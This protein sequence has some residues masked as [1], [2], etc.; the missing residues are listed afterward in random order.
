[1]ASYSSKANPIGSKTAWQEAH[2]GLRR[3]IAERSLAVAVG[4][5]FI[6]LVSTPAGGG[7]MLVHKMASR[8]S[9]PRRMNEVRFSWARPASMPAWVSR[10][11]RSV[12]FMSALA[13]VPA[14]AP[15]GLG[16]P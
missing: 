12:A 2:S 16:K 11:A 13:Q 7:G 3:C 9:L 4:E 14:A 10:P 8:I 5:M 15:A 1:M 6:S